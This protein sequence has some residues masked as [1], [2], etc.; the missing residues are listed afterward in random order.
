MNGAISQFS[1]LSDLEE[2]TGW[3][4]G[5]FKVIIQ[6]GW[7]NPQMGGTIFSIWEGG[8]GGVELISQDSM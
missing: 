5:K 1:Y 2:L 3:R 7:D 6:N 4:E 8:G